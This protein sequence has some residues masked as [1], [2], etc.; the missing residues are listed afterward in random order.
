MCY[1]DLASLAVGIRTQ[2]ANYKYSVSPIGKNG[3]STFAIPLNKSLKGYTGVV[4]LFGTNPRDKITQGV[5]CETKKAGDLPMLGEVT[6]TEVKCPG[7][8]NPLR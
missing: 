1:S 7:N 4:G 3:V 8:S 5:V 2:T 6:A